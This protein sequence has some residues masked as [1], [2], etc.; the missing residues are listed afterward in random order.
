MLA[1]F[2]AAMR[3]SWALARFTTTAPP[4]LTEAAA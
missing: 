2:P 3:R 4:G 1:R